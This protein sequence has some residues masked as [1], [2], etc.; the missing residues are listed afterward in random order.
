MNTKEDKQITFFVQ[1]N[2]NLVYMLMMLFNMP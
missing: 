2:H 1:L